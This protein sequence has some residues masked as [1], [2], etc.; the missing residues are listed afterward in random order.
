ME[1]AYISVALFVRLT[2]TARVPLRGDLRKNVEHRPGSPAV[3]A[4]SPPETADM[5]TP[6]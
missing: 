3:S 2:T 1:T 6:P 4:A 5:V